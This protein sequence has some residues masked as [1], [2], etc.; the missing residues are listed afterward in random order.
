MFATQS[1]NPFAGTN[2]VGIE[3]APKSNASQ[4]DS[5]DTDSSFEETTLSPSLFKFVAS[6]KQAQAEYEREGLRMD[7]KVG[8]EFAAQQKY[9]DD[10]RFV[11]QSMGLGKRVPKRPERLIERI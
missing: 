6:K 2:I 8:R 10:C 9:M 3:W 7:D 5:T 11:L 4:G 1:T